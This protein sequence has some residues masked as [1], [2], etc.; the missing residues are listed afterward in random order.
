MGE[1]VCDP[2]IATDA[3]FRV[4]LVALVDIQVSVEL[5]PDVMVV[6]FA[7]IPAVGGDGPTVTV[8]W[9][10]AVAP[11]EDVATRYM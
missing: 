1:T 5:L 8:A 9:A 7:V 11:D 2:L 3:P 10:D 4:A 6:G